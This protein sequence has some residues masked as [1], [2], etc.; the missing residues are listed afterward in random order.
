MSGRKFTCPKCGNTERRKIQEIEDKS[1]KPLYFAMQG[2]PVYPKK[3]HCG[4]CSHEW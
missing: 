3:L 2:T 1:Q 4:K